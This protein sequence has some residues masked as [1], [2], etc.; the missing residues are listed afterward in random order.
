[1]SEYTPATDEV[2]AYY[3]NG[4]INRNDP[5]CPV[6]AE[7]D[8]WLA[9]HDAEVE[10]AAATGALREAAKWFFDR[11]YDGT[12]HT[13]KSFIK[14]LLHYADQGADIR[15]L[16]DLYVYRESEIVERERATVW[17]TLIE[18]AEEIAEKESAYSESAK[19]LRE[20][21]QWADSNRY[22]NYALGLSMAVRLLRA[23]AVDYQREEA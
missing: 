12:R 9:K 3:A 10:R 1:M 15:D 22:S 7:F 5:S 20:D 14:F 17:K 21:Q 16:T 2:R 11:E 19:R 13:A 23:K 18:A 8:R 6:R 4:Q